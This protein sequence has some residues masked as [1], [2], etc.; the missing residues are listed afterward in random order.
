VPSALCPLLYSGMVSL[1][2]ARCAS[3]VSSA[4][5][6]IGRVDRD[7]LVFEF[8]LRMVTLPESLS[9]ARCLAGFHS[10]AQWTVWTVAWG[11]FE[12]AAQILNFLCAGFR[13][14]PTEIKL[15]CSVGRGQTQ[16]RKS[17]L[18]K[19]LLCYLRCQ[20]TWST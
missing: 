4:S 15:F 7:G 20:Q 1:H 6:K 12:I 16:A 5:G 9:A 13:G 19:R 11:N 2:A 18:E 8:G 14:S 10:S 17:Q 3:L